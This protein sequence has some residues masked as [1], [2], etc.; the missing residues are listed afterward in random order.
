M[1]IKK[2]L[3]TGG[4]IASLMGAS[5]TQSL[6]VVNLKING[7]DVM[8]ELDLKSGPKVGEILEKLFEEVVEKKVENERDTL[9]KRLETFT[10]KS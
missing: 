6:A 5:I 8:K 3:I 7:N 1:D 10:P 2:L 4:T 9:L